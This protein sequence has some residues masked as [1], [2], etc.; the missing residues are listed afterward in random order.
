MLVLDQGS[1]L[2]RRHLYFLLL[3]LAASLLFWGTVRS[4]IRFALTHD[5]DSHIFLI[6]P[7]SAYLIYRKH[8]EIFS[9]VR[10]DVAV[11]A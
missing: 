4:L 5:Y 8:H 3:A 10:T 9:N 11:I 6:V 2:S 7:I 1:S